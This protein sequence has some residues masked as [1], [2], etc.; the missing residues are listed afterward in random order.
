[1]HMVG[2]FE[3]PVVAV[4]A[5]WQPKAADTGDCR[6]SLER[7]SLLAVIVRYGRSCTCS[8]LACDSNPS[9]ATT[10]VL[11]CSTEPHTLFAY[12][13]VYPYILPPS[14]RTGSMRGARAQTRGFGH[15]LVTRHTPVVPSHT[16]SLPQ[17]F[18]LPPHSHF[19]TCAT[20]KHKTF[21]LT[22]KHTYT[23][24]YY[25][26]TCSHCPHPVSDNLVESED[27]ISLDNGC[28]CCSLRKDV[29]KALAEIERRSRYR[30]KRVDQVRGSEVP[31]D[32]DLGRG[33][34]ARRA[35]PRTL[36]P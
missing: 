7:I 33:C 12:Q 36:Q 11:V 24:Q 34:E 17:Y 3:Y 22:Y 29:V 13:S 18:R 28:V 14:N 27:L 16:D 9:K 21:V 10:A 23:P 35:A 6:P 5:S 30:N 1:M 19:K 4:T 31:V 8:M 15:T 20:N 32:S 26:Y 25:S 2:G